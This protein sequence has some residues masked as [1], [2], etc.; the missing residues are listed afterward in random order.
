MVLTVG[1]KTNKELAAWFGI[2]PGSFGT[3][4]AKKLEELEYFANF[5]LEGTKVVIDEVLIPE[6]TKQS[7]ANY[8][9]VK[10]RIDTTWS[11]TGLDT[12]ARVSKEIY[13][14]LTKEDEN[15]NLQNST[16][17]NYTRRGRNELYGKPFSAGGELG[18][19]EYVWAKKTD[20][21][22]EFLNEKEAAIRDTLIKKYFGDATQKQLMVTQMVKEGELKSEDAFEYLQ[23]I[24]GMTTERFSVFLDELQEK[25]GCFIVKATYVDRSAFESGGDPQL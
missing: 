25:I 4:K 16:V 2:T 9:K 19:C 22:Y 24:T 18:K 6:Y 13:Q 12:C 1:K 17:Y 10:C 15:F 21:G 14:L 11:K 8:Q 5:H 23:Y 7:S 3:K 20:T